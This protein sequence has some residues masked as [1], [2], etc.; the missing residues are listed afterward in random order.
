MLYKMKGSQIDK[1]F[2][3]NCEKDWK[4]E[5]D[6]VYHKRPQHQSEENLNQI[7]KNLSYEITADSN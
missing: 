6:G 7:W 3:M 1:G 2:G 5:K 4:N